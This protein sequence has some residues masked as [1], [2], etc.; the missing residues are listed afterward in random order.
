M[1]RWDSPLFTVTW[2]DDLPAEEIWKAVTEGN[3]KPPN[4]GTQAV[5]TRASSS[6]Y[7][8]V[9]CIFYAILPP[10]QSRPAHFPSPVPYFRPSSSLF[11]LFLSFR[12]AHAV[13]PYSLGPDP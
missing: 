6:F 2:T 10:H 8:F 13:P 9:L 7:L 5:R 11:A 12:S 1:V 4:A 3:V